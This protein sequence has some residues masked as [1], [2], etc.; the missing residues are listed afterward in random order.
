MTCLAGRFLT[1]HVRKF[2]EEEIAEEEKEE[3]KE[4]EEEENPPKTK[5]HKIIPGYQTL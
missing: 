5:C 2:K 4:E 1:S 3:E